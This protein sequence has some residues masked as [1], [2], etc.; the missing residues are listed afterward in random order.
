MCR[1]RVAYRFK[2]SINTKKTQIVF[3]PINKGFERF[4]LF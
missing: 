1:I 4:E 3:E 2:N